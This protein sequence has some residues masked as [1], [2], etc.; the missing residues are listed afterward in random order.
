[1][2]IHLSTWL[3]GTQTKVKG[4]SKHPTDDG[5]QRLPHVSSILFCKIEFHCCC[6][7]IFISLPPNLLGVCIGDNINN[8]IFSWRNKL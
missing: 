2:L 5:N 8:V 3:R 1:M 7:F 4:L 6:L